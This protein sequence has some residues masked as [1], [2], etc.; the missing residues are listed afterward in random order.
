MTTV[1]IYVGDEATAAGYRLAGVMPLVPEDG[2]ETAALRDALARASL[3]LVSSAVAARI[4]RGAWRDAITAMS[5][6]VSVVPDVDGAVPLPDVSAALRAEI[7]LS[8]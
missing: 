6:L 8:A 5:P 1:A 4:D 2:Q 3:V 7:G